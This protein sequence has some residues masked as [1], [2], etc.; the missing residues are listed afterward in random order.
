MNDIIYS[1]KLLRD[2]CDERLKALY[3]EDIPTECAQRVEEELK[4]IEENSAAPTL[5]L[6]INAINKAEQ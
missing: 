5:L 2:M 1:N 6:F 3:G 4:I